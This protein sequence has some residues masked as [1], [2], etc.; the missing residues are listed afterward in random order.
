MVARA[1]TRE[2]AL[3]EVASAAPAT[4][5]LSDEREMR[6]FLWELFEVD[7]RLLGLF[8][9]EGVDRDK[10][11]QLLKKARTHAATLAEA[12]Y[13]GDRRPAHRAADGS[14][15][16]PEVFRGLWREHLR[17]WLWLRQQGD[18]LLIH[19]RKS[20]RFPHI[21]NQVVA[22]LF[23]GANPSFMTYAGFTPAAVGLIR[24]RGSELQ[25]QVMLE[26]LSSMEWDACFCATEPDAGSDLSAIA[27]TGRKLDGEVYAVRGEKRYISAGMH[28]LTGN[29]VY[30]V[31]GRVQ[32][33]STSA[34]S[35]SCFLVPRFWREADGSLS[36][37]HV[38]CARVEDKMG[39]NGCANTHLVFGRSGT[40]RG[41]L[42]GNKANVA[43]LQLAALMRKARIRTGGMGL[44]MASSAYLHS[45]RYAR[46][47]VQGVPFDQS[48]NPKAAK[49]KIVQ[50]RDV[51]RMLLE[52]KAKVEGCRALLG[53]IS[54]HSSLIQHF[55]NKPQ[56]ESRQ[57]VDE[58]VV[59][60]HT[61]LAS[62]Y[63]PI[64][65]AY[66]SDEAWN[67]VT[68]AIQVHGAVG[69]LRDRPLE[70]YARDIKILSIW[71]GTN[72]IQAQDLVRDKLGF[73]RQS[74]VMRDFEEEVA[75]CLGKSAEFPELAPEFQRLSAALA[76]LRSTLDCVAE[77]AD[78][79]RLLEISQFCTRLLAMFGEFIVGWNLMEAACVAAKRLR[80][81]APSDADRP[82]YRGKIKTA[83]FY[84]HNILPGVGAKAAILKAGHA[85]YVEMQSDE[86]GFH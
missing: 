63:A 86:F 42:L 59:R 58:E 11:E 30:I 32:G 84:V 29:T 23:T 27:S 15:V 75:Q 73:G 31:L 21:V 41:Y 49:V 13:E 33:A 9:Y 76:D 5:Y 78:Q 71:E 56:P 52:M 74:L 79:A 14:V 66:V 16:I 70:Q 77:Q 24:A 40:S 19:D 47:R 46:E 4:V 62:F 17:D 61:R 18:D 1:I 20:G 2:E 3:H 68:S 54:F 43:L 35:L 67:I 22:E 39:L 85:S 36:P 72:Y 64:A 26:K 28:P 34:L 57:V 60:R 51:Q 7:R 37:N 12:F 81:L 80:E 82:F 10:V 45:L 83:K 50:H 25:K 44:A 55:I 48:S 65:K 69:Y 53:R 6:F 38:E 8:P